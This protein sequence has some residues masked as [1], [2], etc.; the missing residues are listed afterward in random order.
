MES[1]A[2]GAF[3]SSTDLGH[4]QSG[5]GGGGPPELLLVAEGAAAVARLSEAPGDC[6]V[7]L[8]TVSNSA[9]SQVSPAEKGELFVYRL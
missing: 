9:G 1:P 5:S 6:V 8:L 2:N 7:R 3:R 4:A